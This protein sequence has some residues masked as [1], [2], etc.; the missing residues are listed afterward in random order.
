MGD[1]YEGSANRETWTLNLWLN[2]DQGLYLH[3]LEIANAA[4]ADYTAFC[5]EHGWEPNDK[6]RAFRIG[7]DI[8]QWVKDDDFPDH[9]IREV[10]SVWRVDQAAVGESWLEAITEGQE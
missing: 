9:V 5:E 8:L 1:E 6:S 7:D 2:N 10:G 4:S 3:T